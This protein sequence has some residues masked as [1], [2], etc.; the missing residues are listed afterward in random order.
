MAGSDDS[1]MMHTALP[2]PPLPSLNVT[3]AD[4]DDALEDVRGGPGEEA[5]VI[6]GVVDRQTRKPGASLHRADS[7]GIRPVRLPT[8]GVLETPRKADALSCLACAQAM[9]AFH[10]GARPSWG[11][12]FVAASA[13]WCAPLRKYVVWGG[14]LRAPEQATEPPEVP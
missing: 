5:Y 10:A 11:D 2:P 7:S 1:R 4:A 12:A 14:R 8:A 6:G 9:M 13:M 3:S